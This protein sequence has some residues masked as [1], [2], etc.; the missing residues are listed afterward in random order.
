LRVPPGPA[1]RRLLAPGTLPGLGQEPRA[2]AMPCPPQTTAARPHPSRARTGFRPCSRCGQ[3]WRTSTT[4]TT[5]VRS[6]VANNC[7]RFSRTKPRVSAAVR[8]YC[9]FPPGRGF[10]R[11]RRAQ[12]G[13]VAGDEGQ[14]RGRELRASGEGVCRV[15]ALSL[16]W[17]P[18]I[19]HE[20][21]LEVGQDTELG[22]DDGALWVA[23]DVLILPS[24]ISQMPVR[25]AFTR[26]P[27]GKH[28]EGR[29]QRAVV[30]FL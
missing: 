21:G 16:S 6:P 28:S 23:V 8:D 29:G 22:E 5:W 24:S 20:R 19:W 10:S 9:S 2:R 15:H 14:P 13:L 30:R 26:F 12:A 27:V 3:N 1:A 25:G 17:A 4:P 7:G 11:R 18:P